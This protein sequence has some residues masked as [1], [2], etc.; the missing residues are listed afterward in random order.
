MTDAMTGSE[1]G[2]RIMPGT[3]RASRMKFNQAC[4]RSG[5]TGRFAVLWRRSNVNDDDRHAGHG[6]GEGNER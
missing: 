4:R 3:V 6:K 2:P 1:T 5:K